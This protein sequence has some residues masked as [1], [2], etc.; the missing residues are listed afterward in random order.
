MLTPHLT[1]EA[2][3]QHLAKV[4]KARIEDG[5]EVPPPLDKSMR[6]KARP[7]LKPTVSASNST[8]AEEEEP[9]RSTLLPPRK[10]GR[11]GA[12][13]GAGITKRCRSKPQKNT[14]M[15]AHSSMS[16]IDSIQSFDQTIADNPTIQHH[17][18]PTVQSFDPMSPALVAGQSTSSRMAS[19]LSNRNLT[20]DQRQMLEF[21]IT[22]AEIDQHKA[23][24]EVNEPH[25]DGVRNDVFLGVG[26]PTKPISVSQLFPPIHLSTNGLGSSEG[27]SSTPGLHAADLSENQRLTDDST[28]YASLTSV[29]HTNLHALDSVEPGPSEQRKWSSQI[30]GSDGSSYD[31]VMNGGNDAFAAFQHAMPSKS[32]L[33]TT[34]SKAAPVLRTSASSMAPCNYS[35]Q[36]AVA[37]LGA[38][39]SGLMDFAIPDVACM[40]T[41][42]SPQ[43]AFHDQEFQSVTGRPL[44][45]PDSY[46]MC[47]PVE[48]TDLLDHNVWPDHMPGTD[49]VPERLE[50]VTSSQLSICQSDIAHGHDKLL[51]PCTASKS[52]VESHDL[53]TSFPEYQYGGVV[54]TGE[55][56]ESS[57]AID[58]FI[59]VCAFDADTFV[60]NYIS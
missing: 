26:N 31:E 1:S 37:H 44:W 23:V 34:S 2:I 18:Q 15:A 25:L 16:P 57:A 8:Y 19:L 45:M 59:D 32:S 50:S 24:L 55:H 13:K 56:W 36:C 28:A 46:P 11:R 43:Q 49:T 20:A 21:N 38:Y 3:K 12:K 47:R 27:L 54:N 40:H 22:N 17:F 30:F 48:Q 14:T 7:M 53:Q 60:D 6:R 29:E 4:R 41:S 39:N 42:N 5:Y 33:S 35:A 58:P 9:K 10:L 51:F 52:P